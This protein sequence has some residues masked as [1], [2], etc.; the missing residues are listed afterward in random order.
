MEYDTIT[1]LEGNI[2]KEIYVLSEI[3][4]QGHYIIYSD[5]PLKEIDKNHIYVG[6]EKDNQLIPVSEE[7]LKYFDQ[8]F[9]NLI[10]QIANK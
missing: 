10:N 4:N 3:N 9:D 5:I 1:I 7:K 2:E 8:Y 6:E